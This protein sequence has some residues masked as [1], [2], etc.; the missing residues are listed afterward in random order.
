MKSHNILLVQYW[1]IN[2]HSMLRR[3]REETLSLPEDWEG[4]TSSLL[5]YPYFIRLYSPEG[6]G[7]LLLLRSA[8]RGY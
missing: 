6:G 1:I 3:L 5:A 8:Y 4:K 7:C 2:D